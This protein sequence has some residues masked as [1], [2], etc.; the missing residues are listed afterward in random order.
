VTRLAPG[1]QAPFDAMAAVVDACARWD[2]PSLVGP[3]RAETFNLCLAAFR[4]PPGQVS[5]I[6][7]Y[8]ANILRISCRVRP[9]AEAEHPPCAQRRQPN[10]VHHK[11]TA[12]GHLL[13]TTLSRPGT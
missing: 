4:C 2:L 5:A 8:E 1:L 6:V 9:D 7:Y 13:W 3:A 12:N 10:A 11:I